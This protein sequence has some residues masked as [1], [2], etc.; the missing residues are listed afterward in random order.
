M[1]FLPGHTLSLITYTPLVGALVLLLP[2]FRTNDNAVK[3][4][5]N[6]FGLL[7][8]I[9]SLPLWTSFDR[10]KDGFQFVEK[11]DWIP[12]IGV[13]YYFG[14]DGVSALLILLTTMLGFIA[15]L[16]SWTAVHERVRQYY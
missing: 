3:W 2:F 11:G 14:V 4:V 16:S 10:Q 15:I 13:Q 1:D 12:S 6:G 9:V 7:G 5:A 8:F